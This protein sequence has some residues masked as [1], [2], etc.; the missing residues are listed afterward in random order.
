M[1]FQEDFGLRK[2]PLGNAFLSSF[3]ELSPCVSPGTVL[4]TGQD[5]TVAVEHLQR[6]KD[7]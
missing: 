4:L 6:L 5:S 3:I 2:A 1:N 7:T